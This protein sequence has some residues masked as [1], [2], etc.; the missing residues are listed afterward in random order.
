VCLLYVG[1]D[2]LYSSRVVCVIKER[3]RVWGFFGVLSPLRKGR[4]F[5]GLSECFPS[6]F[7]ALNRE[8]SIPRFMTI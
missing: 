1:V 4:K 2:V 5:F 3:G 6:V 7:S 8:F